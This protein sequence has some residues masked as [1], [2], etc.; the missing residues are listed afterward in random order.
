MLWYELL[1]RCRQAGLP[2]EQEE[3]L[4]S[5]FGTAII[6]DRHR[7]ALVSWRVLLTSLRVALEMSGERAVISD[8]EQLLGLCNR[9]DSEA[10]IPLSTDDLSSLH[11]RRILQYM[12]VV[13]AVV[14]VGLKDGWC[15]KGGLKQANA[16]AWYGHWIRLGASGARVEVDLRKWSQH[17]ETPVWLTIAGKDWKDYSA[18]WRALSPLAQEIP[19]RALIDE[20]QKRPVVPLYLPTGV[21][22]DRVVA[23]VVQQLRSVYEMLGHAV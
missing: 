11:P 22:F 8:V 5:E 14:Q 3:V 15:S 1:N 16:P 23:T 2:I 19:P 20:I 18:E 12:R 7:I 21:E 10:F 6:D 4:K 17:C 9:M 13:D